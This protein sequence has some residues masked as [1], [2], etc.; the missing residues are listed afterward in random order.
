MMIRILF[1][2]TCLF[3]LT[4][5]SYGGEIA[6][7]QS[8]DKRITVEVLQHEKLYYRV[9]FNGVYLIQASPLG[10]TLNGVQRRLILFFAT[11]MYLYWM[12]QKKTQAD[13]FF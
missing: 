7:I 4:N 1:I 13:V 12:E 10:V 2:T 3:L 8:P 9:S 11:L 5:I 6:R